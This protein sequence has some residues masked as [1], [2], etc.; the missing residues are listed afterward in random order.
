MIKR[1]FH[2][3]KHIFSTSAPLDETFQNFKALSDIFKWPVILKLHEKVPS[4]L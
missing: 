1:I 2:V 4:N 3:F